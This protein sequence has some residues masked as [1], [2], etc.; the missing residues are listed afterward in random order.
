MTIFCRLTLAAAF[1]GIGAWVWASPPRVSGNRPVVIE[2]P[3]PEADAHDSAP[4][5]AHDRGFLAAALPDD[6]TDADES[7][8]AAKQRT[9]EGELDRARRKLLKVSSVSA[10]IVETITLSERSFK[11]E[12]RYL[13]TGL[14][15]SDWRLR[16]ELVVKIGDTEGS[17]LEVCDGGV[18]WTRTEV[19]LSKKKDRKDRKEIT[20]T[21]RDVAQI[22]SAARKSI[23][24]GKQRELVASLGL[25]GL[26]AL[27]AAVEKEMKFSPS[28]REET[29][30]DRPVFVIQGSWTDA[31]K[32]RL[33]DQSGRGAP[34]LLLALLPDSVRL[35][36]D[37]ET[38]VP[39]RILYL[40][41]IP[42]REV[43]R[44]MLTLDFLDVELDQPI[45]QGEFNYK[46]PDGII[47]VEQTKVFVDMLT[48]AE[49]QVQPQKPSR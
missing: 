14:K 20:V 44:P 39:L 40:K 46:P 49:A 8:D 37:R 41:K 19:D 35:S 12:G 28:V 27:I 18:L 32:A 42:G 48:A 7:A 29:L 38:G 17:L 23:D 1:I 26:P 11:A 34:N 5:P 45:N 4:L 25:G 9:P 30:R 10:T 15:P 21:R 47:P 24:E 36:I 33:G 13:Q 3:V 22:M 2:V 31:Y 16:L 43:S 6:K